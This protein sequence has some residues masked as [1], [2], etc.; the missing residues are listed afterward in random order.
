M[1]TTN[2]M[3]SFL[4]QLRL[5]MSERSGIEITNVIVEADEAPMLPASFAQSVSFD[6]DCSCDFDASF[7]EE[8][9]DSFGNHQQNDPPRRRCGRHE[10]S[11]LPVEESQ[12]SSPKRQESVP[13]APQRKESFELCWET[14]PSPRKGGNNSSG[15]I[16]SSFLEKCVFA[17][18]SRTIVDR[19]MARTQY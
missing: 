3:A 6:P 13:R 5:D 8:R 9:W 18:P 17:P 16:E 19:A 12:P 7:R 15:S 2:P 11:C 10:S 4:K 1:S 14:Q